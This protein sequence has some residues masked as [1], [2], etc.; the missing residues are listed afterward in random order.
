[1]ACKAKECEHFID[2]TW[3]TNCNCDHILHISESGMCSDYKKKINLESVPAEELIG[4][5]AKRKAIILVNPL[6]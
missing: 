6:R 3:P 5:L 2:G 4:E 1:M